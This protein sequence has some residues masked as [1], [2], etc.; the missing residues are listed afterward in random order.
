[1]IKAALFDLDGV[2]IDSE[3]GY[4]RFWKDLGDHYGFKPSFA[5]DIKGTTLTDILERY[6][7]DSATKQ[8]VTRRIYEYEHTMEYPIFEGVV[9][10]L[11]ELRNSGIKT[12]LVTSSDDTKMSFLSSRHPRLLELFDF[13]ITGSMVSKSKPDPEGYQLAARS[14]DVDP[15]ECIVFEDS[16]QGIEAGERSGATV[17]GVATTNPYE[18]VKEK[19]DKVIT[20][21]K[22]LHIKDL[23]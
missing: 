21:F 3:T 20:G 6:F 2:V 19:T 5:Y 22:N 16:F 4:T 18:A 12:A 7:P 23:F 15:T 9:P 1:M 10:F 11:N 13:V 14:L 8:E 17:Y